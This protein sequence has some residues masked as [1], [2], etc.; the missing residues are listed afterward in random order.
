VDA[1][2]N[3]ARWTNAME[4]ATQET[5]SFGAALFAVHG[6]IPGTPHTDSMKGSMDTYARQGWI[7]RDDRYAA[8]PII[9][10]KRV[11]TE[12]DFTTPDEI[13]RRP[14]YQEFLRPFG[15]RWFAG[16]KVASGGDLWVLSIQRSIPQGPFSETELQSLSFL[17]ERLASAA[18]MAGALGFARADAAL[19]AFQAS[20]TAVVLVDRQGRIYRANAAAEALLGSDLAIQGRRLVSTNR[21][22]TAAL[23]RALH[24][25]IWQQREISLEQPIVL[26]RATS[27]PILAYPMRLSS[28][29][30]QVMTPAMAAI[31][32]V[33][34]NARNNDSRAVLRR[35][36]G[37]TAAEA[38]L[39]SALATGESLQRI[40]EALGINYET[41]RSRLKSV[42]A[43]TETSR[44]AE[45]ATLVSRL[46]VRTPR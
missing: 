18:G 25:L 5:E 13:T 15:L 2:I 42:F 3:P 12:F 10:S 46:Q 29:A 19:D 22:V 38:E 8:V 40:T 26:P 14:Y 32:L 39:A 16:V 37:L 9:V 44:Q 24:S 17:S 34:L 43:K 28:L 6:R 36:F 4:I 31:V 1:A 20:G 27:R 41:G 21:E 33:D 23:D 7:H 30:Q 35:V 11:A 45:L